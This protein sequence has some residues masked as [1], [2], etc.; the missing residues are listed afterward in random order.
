[1]GDLEM[2]CVFLYPQIN[3][4]ETNN[5]DDGF[6]HARSSALL[7]GAK[8]GTHRA[9]TWLA[10]PLPRELVKQALE[11]RHTSKEVS[12]PGEGDC[13]VSLKDVQ[14]ANCV[15]CVEACS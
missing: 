13:T 4:I 12:Q 5:D 1:M 15:A 11:G 2:A 9:I 3:K 8:G 6:P 10:S 7:R 14:E